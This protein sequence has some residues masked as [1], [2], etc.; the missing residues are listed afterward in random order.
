MGK[1][2]LIFLLFSIFFIAGC[3]QT[4]NPAQFQEINAPKAAILPSKNEITSKT[5][6][7]I[8]PFKGKYPTINQTATVALTNLLNSYP[9]VKILNRNFKSLKQEI[10]LAELAEN[11][12]TNLNQANYIIFGKILS[13]TTQSVYHPPQY[14][15][16]KKGRY[17]EIPSYY[18]NRACVQ[19]VLKIVKIPQ[20]YVA[21]TKYFSNC[22]YEDDSYSLYDFTP[23]LIKTTNEAVYSLKDYLYRFFA[24]RG[25][26]FD[27]R[28]KGDTEILHTTLGSDFGA[29]E[30]AKVDIYTIKKIKIPFTDET[31]TQ[32]VKIGTG[33]ISNVVNKNDSWIIV[34][35]LNQ[36]VKIGDF[37]KMNFEHSF[38]DIFR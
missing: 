14:W 15:K 23:L 22:V 19:G 25:Y 30:G 3:S 36:P 8:V 10:K 4:I 12:N 9:P 20:N 13:V 5:Q 16:D 11:S 2:S 6:I 24:K 28:K 17:H 35:K 29:K 38:W 7:L 18:E 27:I 21:S 31:K 37:I 33:E 1:K 34:K 26:V 32:I